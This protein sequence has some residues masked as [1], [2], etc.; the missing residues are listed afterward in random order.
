MM[1]PPR[2][3]AAAAEEADERREQQHH[4]DDDHHPRQLFVGVDLGTSG[5][6]ISVVD[7]SA[8]EVFASSTA[9]TSSSAGSRGAG[10][11]R[12][13]DPAAWWGAATRLFREASGAVGDLG[14]G[15]RA[16]C[17]S[18][19]S[20]SCLVVDPSLE[21]LE[22][23]R[24]YNFH[25]VRSSE[26]PASGVEA[27]D[28]IG[29]RVPPRHTA[30][31]PTGTLAKLL[32]WQAQNPLGGGTAR[33]VHQADYVSARAM[34]AGNTGGAR[35]PCGTAAARHN[36][37]ESV[38]LPSDFHNCLKLGYDPAS[39][40]WP[41]WMEPLLLE[42]GLTM[43]V[44]PSPVVSPGEPVGTVAPWV[45]REWGIPEGAAVCGGTTDSNAAFVAA[46]GLRPV[47]G[48]AV[49][50]LGSTLA[51]KQLSAVAVEDADLGV[52]SHALPA[53]IKVRLP[54]ASSHGQERQW[55]L[56]GGAS[57]AGCAVLRQ[58]GFADEE[59]AELSS[60]IDPGTDSPYEYYPLASAGERFPVADAAMAPVLDPRPGDRAEY[61][62][63]LLQG[64]ARV[65]ARGYRA[66]RGLGARPPPRVVLTAGGGSRNGAWTAM[67]ER[68]LAD[69]LGA[70]GGGAGG[71]QTFRVLRAE[72]SEAS[73]GAA[74]L[75]AST[76]I[77][78]D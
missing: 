63:G 15:C 50:S 30:R 32:S 78:A 18:G 68:L 61:L 44:L 75:A 40:S 9:W 53:P 43:R 10:G 70:S 7:G 49:T 46:A 37:G 21:V 41:P 71:N 54:G 13:D 55:W 47:P 39:R 52:Y 35:P 69:A 29:E 45:A 72:N 60:S 22:R 67:R 65:E 3:G 14:S 4:R 6:R 73:Y 57:N 48:T 64:I 31:S 36:L 1:M 76:F 16:V 20:A 11:G 59:L 66:L 27:L 12:Y 38:C 17:V 25:V 2:M 24:M 77:A 56:V 23:P 5:A 28:R 8:R 58:E 74:L 26:F 62:K 19:T 42:A 33:L 51:L 34:G